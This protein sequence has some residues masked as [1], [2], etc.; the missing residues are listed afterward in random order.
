MRKLRIGLIGFGFMGKTHLW[1][2]HNLPFFY[3]AGDAPDALP[4]EAEVAAVCLSP[5]AMADPE[6]ALALTNNKFQRRF[7]A[8][9][10]AAEAQGKTLQEMTLDEMEAVWQAA[11]K[12]E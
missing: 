9:E 1:A 4:F 2:I 3:R 7:N 6:S 10:A 12:E 11:K 5:R 8:I